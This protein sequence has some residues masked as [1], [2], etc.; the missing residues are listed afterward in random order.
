MRITTKEGNEEVIPADTVMVLMPPV[1]NQKL[2]NAI[3]GKVAE[4]H[5]IGCCN[6]VD[7][8]LVVHALKQARETACRI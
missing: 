1:P 4:V 3:S 8:S 5:S 7:Q 2:K 6:G